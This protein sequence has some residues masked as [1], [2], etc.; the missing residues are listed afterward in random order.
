M[1][2]E[3]K[4]KEADSQSTELAV[5]PQNCYVN[6]HEDPKKPLDEFMDMYGEEIHG[7]VA[8]LCSFVGIPGALLGELHGGQPDDYVEFT[9]TE[10]KGPMRPQRKAA[11]G[12]TGG[13]AMLV[14]LGYF[15]PLTL[16]GIN[17]FTYGT[18]RLLASRNRE[19]YQNG[20]T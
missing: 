12:I 5:T 18:A 6:R 1:S 10:A 8:G 16:L 9:E 13:A 7:L 19:K 3:D 15:N 14:S 17:I 20:S 4:C 2:L 11:I